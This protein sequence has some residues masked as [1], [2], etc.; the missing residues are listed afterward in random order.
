MMPNG[1]DTNVPR[2][3]ILPAE[4]TNTMARKTTN[5]EPGFSLNRR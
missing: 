5:T 2:S 3:K 1:N 4:F